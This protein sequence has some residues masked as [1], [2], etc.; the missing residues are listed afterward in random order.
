[1]T[2]LGDVPLIEWQQRP[3]TDQ[4]VVEWPHFSVLPV[5]LSGSPN[6]LL[7]QSQRA[8]DLKQPCMECSDKH[9]DVKSLGAVHR[10]LQQGGHGDRLVM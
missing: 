10:S 5:L 7:F 9:V 1:M 6:D 4:F 3:A 8:H 2:S